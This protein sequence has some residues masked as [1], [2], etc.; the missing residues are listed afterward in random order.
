M[1]DLRKP[2]PLYR[3]LT[4]E[5]VA[6]FVQHRHD[7][8][9]KL[10]TIDVAGK[11][12][13]SAGPG[14]FR[15]RWY[16]PV[17]GDQRIVVVSEDRIGAARQREIPSLLPQI[18]GWLGVRWGAGASF[19]RDGYLKRR[20]WTAQLN[21]LMRL[22]HARARKG[23]LGWDFELLK[24]FFAIGMSPRSLEDGGLSLR[25]L[26]FLGRQ[27]PFTTLDTGY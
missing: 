6:A 4:A 22:S 16:F 24:G 13:S 2:V 19:T 10:K 9:G 14:G 8:P 21:P 5:E 26:W 12:H 25:F 3:S 27:H 11:V 20:C 17:Y 23:P 15:E 7:L 18:S 1:G